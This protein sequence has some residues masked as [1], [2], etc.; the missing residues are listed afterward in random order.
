M[1]SRFQH[2]RI[3]CRFYSLSLKFFRMT[4]IRKT[5]FFVT[6]ASIYY[7][8]SFFRK[9]T[10]VPQNHAP[11]QMEALLPFF[12]RFHFKLFFLFIRFSSSLLLP[13]WHS[14][15]IF[16]IPP[17]ACVHVIRSDF[18]FIGIRT[19]V[20]HCS[21]FAGKLD[22]IC[23]SIWDTRFTFFYTVRAKAYVE[24]VYCVCQA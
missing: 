20:I 23:F 13:F 21:G 14:F 10:F 11:F 15:D 6:F 18:I 17:S 19:L 4:L 1:F 24:T 12:S 16:L 3:V 7:Y 9:K 2:R 22:W 8:Y 5:L